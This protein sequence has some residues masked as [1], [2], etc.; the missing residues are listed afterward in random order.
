MRREFGW[1]LVVCTALAIAAYFVIRSGRLLEG[2]SSPDADP[3]FGVVLWVVFL[4]LGLVFFSLRRLAG[5]R[6]E[7]RGR[8]KAEAQLDLNQALSRAVADDQTELILRFDPDGRLTFANRAY[9]EYRGEEPRALEGRRFFDWLSD[10][11]ALEI[12]SFL[13]SFTPEHPIRVFER[14]P[15]VGE[16][17][18][19]LLHWRVRAFFDPYGVIREY[20]AVGQDVSAQRAYE[21]TVRLYQEKLRSLAAQVSLSEEKERRRIACGIHDH[22]IQKL[23]LIQI[24]L[25][26][27]VKSGEVGAGSLAAARSLV[28][29]VT[30]DA[31]SVVFD[32]S[33]PVLYELG[34]DAAVEWLAEQVE[35]RHGVVC[36]IH[37]DRRERDL[38]ADV[39]V[40][41]FQAL[42]ELLVNVA[43]HSGTHEADIHLARENGHFHLSVHDD[44]QGFDPDSVDASARDRGFGL[45]SIRERLWMLG[46]GMC[47]EARPGAGARITL[48]APLQPQ[49]P[50]DHGHQ[51]SPS[52]RPQHTS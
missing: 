8:L 38:D 28:E 35:E 24:Q 49:S 13:D 33:P 12:R 34:F 44:G 42:R 25:G 2:W 23:G 48:T 15:E 39:Q 18:V 31:R 27:L 7:V 6:R 19:A 36:R 32:L 16:Q 1:S 22:L 40:V 10:C 52:R 47:V 4:S 5:L 41:L 50:A 46:G 21:Q 51:N 30:R 29:E 20:Q 45:F 3:V 37:D 17:P 26:E 43:K 11:T 14:P 9:A